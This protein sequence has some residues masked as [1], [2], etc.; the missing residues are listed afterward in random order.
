MDFFVKPVP[1]DKAAIA[2]TVGDN[3]G[4]PLAS[5]AVLIA[6][7]PAHRDIASLTDSQGRYRFDSL[8]PG[9]YTLLVNAS[10]HP[11]KEGRVA[12]R[13]GGLARLDFVME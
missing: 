13:L 5:A 4:K 12:A 2:G 1:P 10:G 3:H 11:Q 8:L 7:G 9:D 6:G